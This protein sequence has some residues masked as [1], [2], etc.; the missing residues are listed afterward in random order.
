[1]AAAGGLR[2]LASMSPRKTVSSASICDERP[3]GEV[4]KSLHLERAAINQ[5]EFARAEWFWNR[6]PKALCETMTF[7]FCY[8]VVF[9]FLLYLVPHNVPSFLLWSV[10]GVSCAFLDC[11]RIER[12][13]NDYK[14][15]IKRAIDHRSERQC[16]EHYQKVDCCCAMRQTGTQ[17][18]PCDRIVELLTRSGN[19][20]KSRK[21]SVPSR[22]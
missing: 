6:R 3:P 1:M 12:W 15:S 13:R 9:C 17:S 14:S 16:G 7:Y 10:V 5:N 2:S 11:M 8:I 4:I 19:R 18:P 20:R 22:K 21:A